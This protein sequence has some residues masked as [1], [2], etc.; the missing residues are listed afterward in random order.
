MTAAARRPPGPRAPLAIVTQLS[1][2]GER[3]ERVPLASVQGT[4]ALDL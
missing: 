2:P 3:R 1:P 4:L